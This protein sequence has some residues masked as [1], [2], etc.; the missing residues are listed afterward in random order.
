MSSLISLD[1]HVI[2]RETFKSE[3]D[4]RL[5]P[6]HRSVPTDMAYGVDSRIGP[7]GIFNGTTSKIDT[8]SDWLGVGAVTIAA[9]IYAAG[10]GE[11]AGR[12]LGNGK[13]DIYVR[14]TNSSIALFSDGVTFTTSADNSIQLNTWYR[15]LVTR[16][17]AGV[18]NF[19]INGVLSGSADQNSG[20]PIGGTSNAFIG[21]REAADRTF[22]GRIALLEVRDV[23]LTADEVWAL[24]NRR[25]YR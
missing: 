16:T 7:Y 23:V 24:Y 3:L 11:T 17:A 8:Q 22:D 21:N 2:H 10:W 14:S 18:A 4:V 1:R 15:V 6:Y 25:L 19:Y 13:T 20:T 9:T 5:N 12:V